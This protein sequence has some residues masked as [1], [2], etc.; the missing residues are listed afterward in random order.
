[1]HVCIACHDVQIT[2]QEEMARDQNDMLK[3]IVTWKQDDQEKMTIPYTTTVLLIGEW[4][5]HFC[6]WPQVGRWMGQKPV[7]GE[8]QSG[9]SPDDRNLRTEPN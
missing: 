1:M 3:I 8:D 6:S 4:S 2:G 5:R 9:F 7:I